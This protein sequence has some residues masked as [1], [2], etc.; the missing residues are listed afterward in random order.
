L[1]AEIANRVAADELF[2]A[3]ACRCAQR[4]PLLSLIP[5][6]L[7]GL[8]EKGDGWRSRHKAGHTVEAHLGIAADIGYYR[9]PAA[10]HRFDQGDRRAFAARRK[11]EQMVLLPDRRDIRHVAVEMHVVE[12]QITRHAP[13]T[14][15]ARTIA[16]EMEV[17]WSAAPN[18]QRK[19]LQQ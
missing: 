15:F 17:H 12:L 7:H 11:H 5:S 6:A 10:P 19:D 13:Q 2:D 8:I 1:L 14:L 18:W 4:L 3:L 16:I 9:R